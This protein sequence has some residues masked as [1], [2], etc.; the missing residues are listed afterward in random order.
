MR[1][2][3]RVFFLREFS[4][5]ARIFPDVEDFPLELRIL[6]RVKEQGRNKTANNINNFLKA[7]LTINRYKNIMKT[8]NKKAIGYNNKSGELLKKFK[9]I[10]DFL[11]NVDQSRA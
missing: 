6:Y 1:I 7:I 5:R 11:D 2:F 4:R 10:E 3:L 9:N 8:Q